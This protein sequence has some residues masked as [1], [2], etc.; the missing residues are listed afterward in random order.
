MA[1]AFFPIAELLPNRLAYKT[2]RRQRQLGCRASAPGPL[3]QGESCLMG[4][5]VSWFDF[6]QQNL[7]QS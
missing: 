7:R 3:A 2:N 6:A 5:V 1:R 4:A